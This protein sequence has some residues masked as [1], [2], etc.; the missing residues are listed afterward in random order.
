MKRYVI[1]NNQ[2]YKRITRSEAKKHYNMDHVVI[3]TLVGTLPFIHN[4]WDS[5]YKPSLFNDSFEDAVFNYSIRTGSGKKCT[6]YI[7]VQMFTDAYD[8]NAWQILKAI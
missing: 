1:D 8:N 6:Y 2:R 4:L 3:V 7:P 5:L